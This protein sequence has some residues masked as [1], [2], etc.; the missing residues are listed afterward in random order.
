M[1]PPLD[2]E[3]LLAP[4]P[5]SVPAMSRV[6]PTAGLA[7]HR[8]GG[9][10]ACRLGLHC[11]HAPN[12]HCQDCRPVGSE[13]TPTSQKGQDRATTK[14]L[15]QKR[16]G[17]AAISS[18]KDK[19]PSALPSRPP[20]GCRA[21]SAGWGWAPPPPVR[22]RPPRAP[23]APRASGAGSRGRAS[24][25]GTCGRWGAGGTGALVAASVRLH[26]QVCG[27]SSKD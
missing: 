3:G 1:A 24:A 17:T 23:W 9:A 27:H 16:A 20:G 21:A 12:L 2:P 11:C 22:H 5:S 25:R 10:P 8:A 6:E 19:W 26:G 7:A 18:S 14:E 13:I 15:V 4:T